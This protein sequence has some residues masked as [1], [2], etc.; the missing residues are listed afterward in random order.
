MHWAG[1]PKTQSHA[2]SGGGAGS[3]G[4]V[5]VSG[6]WGRWPAWA[7]LNRLLILGNESFQPGAASFLQTVLESFHFIKVALDHYLKKTSKI[8]N[9]AGKKRKTQNYM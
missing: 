8:Y 3:C 9:K 4:A 1:G 5:R 7:M 6:V 2:V